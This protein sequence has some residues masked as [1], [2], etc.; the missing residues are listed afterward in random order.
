MTHRFLY[1]ILFCALLFVYSCKSSKSVAE[2]HSDSFAN[3]VEQL[4]SL[5]SDFELENQLFTGFIIENL[6]TEKIVYAHNEDKFFT[7]ASNTKLL[8][9]LAAIDILADSVPALK[10]FQYKDSLFI[11]GTGDPTFLAPYDADSTVYHFL[12]Q[13]DKT[14][15]LN[16]DN[17]KTERFGAGWAWDDFKYY[18]QKENTALPFFNMATL[19]KTHPDSSSHSIHPTFMNQFIQ[20]DFEASLFLKREEQSNIIT[21]N[22]L[23]QVSY[24]RD[25]EVPF[26]ISP[27]F[28]AKSLSE[29]IN[30]QV[31]YSDFDVHEDS[32]LTLYHSSTDSLLKRLML[33][34][35]NF[36]AEQLLFL[37]S[38][39]LDV[40]MNTRIVIRNILDSRF[41]DI[42]DRPRWVDGSGLS[43]YNLITPRSLV[44]VLRRLSESVSQSDIREIFPSADHKGTLPKAMESLSIRAKTGSFSNNFCLSGYL[45]SESGETYIFSWMNNHYMIT[46]NELTESMAKIFR[47]LEKNW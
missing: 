46:K 8:T 41:K 33:F 12:S 6:K 31:G 23:H 10:Y 14:I 4:H 27:D 20:T 19:I 1:W 37:M 22:P 7:P 30:Q 2:V 42:P 38:D 26:Y 28:I 44:W 25:Y 32:L 36:V 47:F 21:I 39:K 43:R 11:L 9:Y 16:T 13:T 35:D 18:Y 40:D 45:T 3:K 29:S 15:L 24:P 34:S 5:I 17:M